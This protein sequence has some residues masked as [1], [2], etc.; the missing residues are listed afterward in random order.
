MMKH[1][2][3][4][5]GRA[6]SGTGLELKRLRVVVG[7]VAISGGRWEFVGCICWIA[8]IGLH[9]PCLTHLH[10][11]AYWEKAIQSHYPARQLWRT[12]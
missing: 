2:A 10:V 11:E 6:E 1:C 12:G 7:G 3:V 8:S 9:C 5:A 4:A